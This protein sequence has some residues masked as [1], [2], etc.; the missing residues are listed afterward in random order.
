MTTFAEVP[1]EWGEENQ[2]SECHPWST[3]PD[4]F[5]FRT[6]CGINP[7][8]AGH[9]TVEITPSFGEQT[10]I[11]AVYPHPLGNIELDLRKVGSRVEGTVSTP[12]EMQCTFVWGKQKLNLKVGKQ[13]IKIEN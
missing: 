7:T 4:Y 2:R 9:K 13:N 6:V 11:K 12:N 3:A 8:S 5:F 10:S 1:L